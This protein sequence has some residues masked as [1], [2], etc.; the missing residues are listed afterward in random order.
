LGRLVTDEAT[1][2]RVQ[3]LGPVRAWRMDQAREGQARGGQERV[4]QELDLGGPQRRAVLAILASTRHVSR[5]ELIDG[6]WGGN[7]PPS[8]EN[9]IH[10]HISGL[11]RTLE[12][13][14]ALRTTGQILTTTGQVYRLQLAPG[15]LDTEMLTRHVADARRL[16]ASSPA[17]AVRSLDIALAL[18][19]GSP[20]AGIPGPWADMERVRLGEL[21]RTTVADRVDILLRLGSHHQVIAELAALIRQYPLHER[22][23][24]QLMLALYRSGRQADALAAF[25]SARRVLAGQLGVDPGPALRLL[26]QQILTADPALDPPRQGSGGRPS[27]DDGTSIGIGSELRRVRAFRAR[28]GGRLLTG[29]PRR[30]G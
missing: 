25:D 27:A 11:R 6:L 17:T 20:L 10:V 15:S 4:G 3:L 24:G 7:P 12:P 5:D 26:Q 16:A 8:A 18:S 28:S 29:P 1:P 13:D 2:L 23:R 9:A 19:K 14:R 22:F 21:R 30:R